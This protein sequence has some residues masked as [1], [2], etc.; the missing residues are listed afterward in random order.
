DAYGCSAEQRAEGVGCGVFGGAPADGSSDEGSNG[1]SDEGSNGGDGSE[2]G[3]DDGAAAPGAGSSNPARDAQALLDNPPETGT[4]V[5]GYVALVIDRDSATPFIFH[6]LASN[7]KEL[8]EGFEVHGAL[9]LTTPLGQLPIANASVVFEY[10]EDRKK[11]LERLRGDVNLPFPSFGATAGFEVSDLVR[12]S[13]G[14]DS[15]KNLAQLDA[16]IAEDR[17]YLFFQFEAG[18]QAKNGP[19]GISLPGGEDG[20]LILDPF[21]PFVFVKGSLFGLDAIGKVE[22]IAIGLSAQGLIPFVPE[23]TY[24]LA[25]GVGEF[26]GH[27]YLS[28]SVPLT[29]LPLT[30]SGDMVLDIDA[31]NQ[32]RHLHQIDQASVELGVNGDIALTVDFFDVLSFEAPIEQATAGILLTEDE[33]RAYL[34]GVLEPDH[35]FLPSELPLR[36]DHRVSVAGLISNEIA[37]SYLVMEGEYTLVGSSLAQRVGL[38][39]SNLAVAQARL[40]IDQRGFRML[41]TLDAGVK[42]ARDL[43]VGGSAKV[44]AF[45]ADDPSDFFVALEGDIAVAGH[46]LLDAKARIDR[47]GL[48]VEGR[49]DTGLTEL[50]VSG[51][52]TRSGAQLTG[53]ATTTIDVQAGHE[54]VSEVVDGVLCGYDQIRSGAVCGYNKIT[55][56]G[57][58]GYEKVTDG[59]RCGYELITSGTKCGYEKITDAVK[60][61][62]ETVTNAVLCGTH[63]VCSWFSWTGLDCDDVASSCKVAKSCDDVT[64]PK[65]CANHDM[66]KS[67]DDVT[68]PKTCDNFLDPKTC[69]DLTRP[70]SCPK[71]EIVPDYDFGTFTGTV[72]LTLGTQGIGGSVN[73]SY[74]PTGGSC[75]TLGGKVKLGDPLEACVDIPGELGEFCAPF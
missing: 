29:R 17:R 47:N 30:I 40:D 37:D 26:E 5:N 62:E 34:S 50:A 8:A 39:L 33:Q 13:I 1:S 42:L 66:P 64:K 16:P 46:E 68:K 55:S 4:L 9:L 49:L 71:T 31:K 24:G 15:G 21:D 32:G 25:A 75:V 65:T 69:D 51:F 22:D 28:G 73:G 63:E 57:Q 59:G 56:G 7:V 11:G 72:S 58:C 10:G 12:A 61:G 20:T 6:T 70:R 48:F 27:V 3:P 38:D 19:V 53:T 36:A 54:I 60:C 43:E 2:K 44:E 74:C 18:F 35:S 67:C 45:F 41:G 14:L 52:I 23:T